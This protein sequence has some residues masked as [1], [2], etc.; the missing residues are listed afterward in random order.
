MRPL[1]RTLGVLCVC[2]FAAGCTPKFLNPMITKETLVT[3][4]TLV[5]E[6]T[7]EAAGD[8]A[9]ASFTASINTTAAEKNLGVFYDLH[10]NFNPEKDANGKPGANGLFLAG[11]ITLGDHLF[12]NITASP[13]PYGT[14]ADAGAMLMHPVFIVARITISGDT[15]TYE[16]FS[17]T[18]FDEL[19]KKED[20]A[21]EHIHTDG[22]GVLISATGE[23]VRAFFTKHGSNANAWKPATTW[24]K[25]P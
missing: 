22:G 10:V 11:F 2:L 20:H 7:C 15:L 6:W 14:Q 9:P 1:L 19:L 3:Q 25:K 13:Q 4:P 18:W 5:G 8:A 23:Q 12:A 24:K 17:D 16:E 21:L